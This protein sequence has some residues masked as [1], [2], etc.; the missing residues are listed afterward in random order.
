[1]ARS[2]GLDMTASIRRFAPGSSLGPSRFILSIEYQ[3][4]LAQKPDNIGLL[5]AA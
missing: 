3:A 2:P 5:L 4:A 1:L